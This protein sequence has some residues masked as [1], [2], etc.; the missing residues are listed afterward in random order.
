MDPRQNVV[1]GVLAVFQHLGVVVKIFGGQ[2]IGQGRD[3]DS[4]VTDLR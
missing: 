1:E 3:D 4:A 2:Q